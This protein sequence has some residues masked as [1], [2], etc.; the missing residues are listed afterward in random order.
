MRA[1]QDAGQRSQ[2]WERA[3]F[4]LWVCVPAAVLSIG[5]FLLA[6]AADLSRPATLRPTVRILAWVGTALWAATTGLGWDD[7]RRIATATRP[8]R[9]AQRYVVASAIV[10][11]LNAATGLSLSLTV[12]L[13]PD[14]VATAF[15]AVATVGAIVTWQAGLAIRVDLDAAAHIR[16]ARPLALPGPR[17]SADSSGRLADPLDALLTELPNAASSAVGILRRPRRHR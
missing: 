2:P 14:A 8:N 12:W 10:A 3:R 15:L 6:V 9:M 16:G 1:D 13:A 11:A 17:H 7:R 4:R 5:L